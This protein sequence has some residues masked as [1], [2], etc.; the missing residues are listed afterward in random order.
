MSVADISF[1]PVALEAP[2]A[3]S[4]IA[5]ATASAKLDY[6][7]GQATSTAVTTAM[8]GNYQRVVCTI[9]ADT[10]AWVAF[11]TTPDCTA[12]A[13]TA[14]TSARQKIPAGTVFTFA[15]NVGDKVAVMTWS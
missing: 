4:C 12:T 10:N 11:G 13:A 3:S 6:S 8:Y 2:H 5:A 15:V 14:T 1:N 9:T 7:A